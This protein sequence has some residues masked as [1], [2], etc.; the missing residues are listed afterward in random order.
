MEHSL[1]LAAKHFVQAIAPHFG[2]KCA[3]SGT[4]AEG[5]TAEDNDNDEDSD[6]EEID[7]RDS[8][9]KAVALVKQVCF[10]VAALL[11]YFRANTRHT[12]HRFASLH[13]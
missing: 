13:R 5:D 11:T 9:G 1:H 6:G 2:K 12:C 7:S 3:T 8:L 10:S 4:D